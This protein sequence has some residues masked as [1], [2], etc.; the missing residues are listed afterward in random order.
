MMEAGKQ[1]GIGRKW[2]AGKRRSVGPKRRNEGR[3]Y[4]L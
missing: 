3:A 2:V 4:R 1:L